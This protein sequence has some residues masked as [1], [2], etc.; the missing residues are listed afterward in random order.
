MAEST[1]TID[2]EA[3]QGPFDLLLHLI[4]EQDIDIN[5]IPMTDITQ[6][7]LGYIKQME[8]Y[9]L[10]IIGDYL[11]MAATLLEIK[12]KLLLPIEPLS[13]LEDDYDDTDPREQLV[14]QL[15]LYQQFQSVATDL[16]KL[17]WQRQ[18]VFTRPAEDL[19]HLT[20]FILL[21]TGE[22]TLN[23]LVTA[24]NDALTKFQQRNPEPQEIHSEKVSVGDQIAFLMAKLAKQEQVVFSDILVSGSRP[25]IIST[26]LAML[27]LVRK[28]VIIFKQE[29][30]VGEIYMTKTGR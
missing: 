22:I 18:K 5:D 21:E 14:Q 11:V 16:E 9:Q 12:S 19:S 29:S 25:E 15:L 20:Q 7:Y 30:R 1:L 2:L 8:H 24:M 27:E 26:F 23:Q 10:D 3:F 28:D 13:D 17:S 6:Q 4:K